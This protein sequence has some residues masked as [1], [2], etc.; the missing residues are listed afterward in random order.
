MADKLELK[1]Q[2]IELLNEAIAIANQKAETFKQSAIDLVAKN[3][4]T[5]EGINFQLERMQDYAK[6][7]KKRITR[8]WINGLWQGAV[9]GVAIIFALL[10]L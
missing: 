8:A 10:L 3:N 7:L 4:A 2:E 6:H 9:A 1:I 5:I